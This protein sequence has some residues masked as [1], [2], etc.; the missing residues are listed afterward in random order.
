MKLIFKSLIFG[1]LMACI[2]SGCGKPE[3]KDTQINTAELV[4]ANLPTGFEKIRYFQTENG[5]YSYALLFSY[6]DS[7]KKLSS[8]SS[9][10]L[11]TANGVSKD[12]SDNSFASPMNEQRLLLLKN[13]FGSKVNEAEIR[14]KMDQLYVI[15]V[16]EPYLNTG[17]YTVELEFVMSQGPTLHTSDSLQLSAP[18]N[19]A[20]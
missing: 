2:L 16:A 10:S 11:V 14:A 1:S 18:A 8:V 20:F 3:E 13:M 12:I 5:L 7:Q 6:K 17:Q 19:S 15:I 9:I 4:K